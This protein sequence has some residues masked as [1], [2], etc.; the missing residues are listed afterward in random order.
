MWAGVWAQEW[1]RGCARGGALVRRGWRAGPCGLDA[2]RRNARRLFSTTDPPCLRGA[3]DEK[4]RI[5]AIEHHQASGNVAAEF[6]PKFLMAV[7]GADFAAYRGAPISYAVPNRETVAWRTALP[8]RTGWWRGLGLLANTFAVESFMDELAHAAG[9]DPLQ[10]RLDHLSDDKDG[11]RTR[12]VL[13]AVGEL[14]GWQETPAAGRARGIAMCTD[15]GTI[16][17][18][19]AEISLDQA[20]GQIIVHNVAAAMDCGL[21]VNP[22]APAPRSRAM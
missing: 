22:D 15:V 18:Q 4:G 9:A 2:Q 11:R 8:V 12:A 1:L 16:V 20:S 7:M 6:L 17:A 21:T 14:S 3:L 10:F 19:V 13:E 5:A